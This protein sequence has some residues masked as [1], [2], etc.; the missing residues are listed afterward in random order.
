[1]TFGMGVAI[2]LATTSVV[3]VIPVDVVTEVTRELFEPMSN[4]EGSAVLGTMLLHTS[5]S[6]CN[7]LVF[8]SG[9]FGVIGAEVQV[10]VVGV[11]VVK[12][13]QVLIE[14]IIGI[15]GMTT[16]RRSYYMICL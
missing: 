10:L 13:I 7:S 1:M 15:I 8:N 2:L 16:G 6:A 14:G 11:D 9:I 5:A 4:G 3:I 12:L